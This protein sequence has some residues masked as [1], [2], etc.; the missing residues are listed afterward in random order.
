MFRRRL[1][2]ALA[3]PSEEADPVSL[4]RRALRKDDARA[5]RKLLGESAVLR[6]AIN[7]P[8]VDFNAPAI[9]R[10][11]SRAMLDANPRSPTRTAGTPERETTRGR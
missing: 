3:G 1:R 6:A 11:R 10:V 2:N 8:M 5:M 4:A 7:E 9:T